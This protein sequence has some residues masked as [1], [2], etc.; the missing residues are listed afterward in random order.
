MTTEAESKLL[1]IS[2]SAA[3]RAAYRGGAITAA[4]N[5]TLVEGHNA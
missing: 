4:N 2:Q 1:G 3:T 5:P